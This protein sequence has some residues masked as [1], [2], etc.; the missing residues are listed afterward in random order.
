[1]LPWKAS[2][3]SAS[4]CQLSSAKPFLPSL[5]PQE[6]AES[7]GWCRTSY[8]NRV[9]LLNPLHRVPQNR[10]QWRMRPQRHP[11]LES[12]PFPRWQLSHIK[13]LKAVKRRMVSLPN[14]V[15]ASPSLISQTPGLQMQSRE[16]RHLCARRWLLHPASDQLL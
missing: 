12:L 15:P 1:M 10:R 16:H 11:R 13:D 5:R 9:N 7:F 2:H 14:A 4:R 8:Y 3:I 6:V